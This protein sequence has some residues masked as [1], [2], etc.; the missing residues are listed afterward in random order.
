MTARQRSEVSLPALPCPCLR[1]ARWHRRSAPPCPRDGRPLLRPQPPLARPTHASSGAQQRPTV[2]TP[3]GC[4]EQLRVEPIGARVPAIG[5]VPSQ[6]PAVNRATLLPGP[7]MNDA[8]IS[9]AQA[10]RAPGQIGILLLPRHGAADHCGACPQQPGNR[11]RIHVRWARLQPCVAVGRSCADLRHHRRSRWP[12]GAHELPQHA[13]NGLVGLQ[14]GCVEDVPE[15]RAQGVLVECQDGQHHR[16]CH[17]SSVRRRQHPADRLSC[18][19]V[20]ATARRHVPGRGD[21]P[22]V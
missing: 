16:V 14:P 7:L 1:R 22:E 18:L 13:Q 10:A 15:P 11:D 19:K 17:R 2:P 9:N 3:E 20:A 6:Q 21:R 4:V 8:V 12:V 5:T